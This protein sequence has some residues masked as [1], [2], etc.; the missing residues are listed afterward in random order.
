MPTDRE[1][2]QLIDAA[3][4]SYSAAEPQPGLE[5]RILTRAFAEQPRRRSLGWTWAFAVPAI[6]CLLI[7]LLLPGHHHIVPH[8]AVGRSAPTSA[9]PPST[10]ADIAAKTTPS[11][12]QPRAPHAHSVVASHLAMREPLPKK[13]IFPS[14]SPLTAEEQTLVA[15]SR[16]QLQTLSSKPIANVDIDP[17]HVA[18]LQIKPLTIPALDTPASNQS[19]SGRNDQKP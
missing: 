15:Y 6:A 9:A 7:F 8:S 17:I 19:E 4:P 13:D 11:P 2:E 18:E 5:H 3:L 14:P 10:E 1:L 12:S 16:A